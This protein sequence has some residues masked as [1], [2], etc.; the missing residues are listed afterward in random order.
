MFIVD[1]QYCGDN[2]V[3]ERSSKRRPRKTPESSE[4][5]I[6][7]KA[8]APVHTENLWAH[9][10]DR[11]GGHQNLID[12]TQ[13]QLLD[14]YFQSTI[15]DSDE[16]SLSEDASD[17]GTSSPDSQFSDQASGSGN[18]KTRK[19][20]TKKARESL[21]PEQIKER[22]RFQ[23]AQGSKKYR[24][25]KRQKMTALK[26]TLAEN[27]RRNTELKERRDSLLEELAQHEHLCSD[28]GRL[29]LG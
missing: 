2:Q 5:L 27:R 4:Q 25:N 20:I 29:N 26:M 11:Y 16:W 21:S 23:L 3:K 1:N 19:R 24:D 22:K 18:G 28:V 9:P 10:S 8:S 7:Q 17:S 13:D 14:D 15:H 6:L 12:R